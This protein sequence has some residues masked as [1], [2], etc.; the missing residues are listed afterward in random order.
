ML[1]ELKRSRR[2]S[3]TELSAAI[4]VSETKVKHTVERLTESGL[5]EAVGTGRGRH[6]TLSAKV[7]QQADDVS[8]YVRQKGI[9]SV[10]YPEMILQYAKS[11]GGKVTRAETA[12]LLRVSPPQAYRQLK[13]LEDAGKLLGIG[14]GKGAYYKIR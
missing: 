13:K 9:D 1:N 10:R 2:A 6:Y 3:I 14:H 7:Y 8:G 12:E 11:N 5:I 4:H